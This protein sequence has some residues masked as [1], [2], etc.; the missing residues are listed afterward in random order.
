MNIDKNIFYN[1]VVSRI[2]KFEGLRLKPYRCTS[3]KLTIGWG[4]NLD[5]IGISKDEAEF[6]FRNDLDICIDSLEKNI[7]FFYDLPEN[8]MKVLIDMRFNLGLAGLLGFKKMLHNISAGDYKQA[9]IEL[10]D[11]KYASQVGIRATENAELL[12]KG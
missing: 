9:A 6:M 3:L 10:L 1:E 4:R 5:D 8:V 7:P 12:V 11:S 2:K